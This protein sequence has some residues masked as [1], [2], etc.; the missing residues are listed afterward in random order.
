MAI[1]NRDQIL[2]ADDASRTVNVEVPEWGGSVKLRVMTGSARDQ[3][4]KGHN[5]EDGANF[6][7]RLAAYSIVDDQGVPIFAEKDVLALGSKSQSAL[8]RI[9]KAA[10]ALNGLRPE[11]TD[12]AEKNS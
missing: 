8:D 2:S 12:E 10:L 5:R 1:L 9:V 7:G 6:R 3:L 11:D 4:E